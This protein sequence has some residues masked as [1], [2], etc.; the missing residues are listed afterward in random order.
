MKKNV[1]FALLL[2]LICSIVFFFGCTANGG[3]GDPTVGRKGDGESVTEDGSFSLMVTLD[4]TEVRIGETI[5]ATVIFKNL[6]G[7]DIEAEIPDWIA[8]NGG[9]SKE[10]IV[11]AI[12][13]PIGAIW[14]F[15]DILFPNRPKI[16]IESGLMIERKFEHTITE[17]E[18]FQV[19]AGAFF[20]T[21]TDHEHT[22]G[23]KIFSNP[24]IIK[25]L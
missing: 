15:P 6:S 22:H 9:L 19:Q 7:R 12:F 14:G 24:I 1:F 23:E 18:N 25:V 13:A 10:D 17:S 16:L 5:T 20:I 4:K 3:N 21:P 8:A 11:T 2:T